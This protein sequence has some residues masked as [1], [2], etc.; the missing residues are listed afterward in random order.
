[1]MRSISS[2]FRQMVSRRDLERT[3]RTTSRHIRENEDAPWRELES[4]LD[5]IVDRYRYESIEDMVMAGDPDAD[6]QWCFEVKRA[7]GLDLPL[8][9]IAAVVRLELVRVKEQAESTAP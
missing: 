4:A 7:L 5:D 8:E 9:M 1:M 6:T 2:T 3:L